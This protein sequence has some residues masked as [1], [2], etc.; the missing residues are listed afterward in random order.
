MWFVKTKV[1][2]LITVVRK[3]KHLKIIQKIHVQPTGKARNKGST[4][5]ALFDI[6]HIL[7]ELLIG[8]TKHSTLRITV[9]IP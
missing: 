7:R 4:E 8:S 9:H 1:I 6:A 3:W 2:P 5:T